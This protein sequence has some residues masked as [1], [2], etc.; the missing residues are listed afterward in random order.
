MASTDLSDATREVRNQAPPLLPLDAFER[1]LALREALTREGGA[2]GIDRVRDAAAVAG[3][4]EA[5]AHGRRA[6]R[7]EPRLLTHDRWGRRI[8][9]VDQP[10]KG[11]AKEA[12]HP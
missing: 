9:E 7:N 3:S 10:G 5:A 11:V 6:E 2:W 4:A 12:R 8:D 1:D